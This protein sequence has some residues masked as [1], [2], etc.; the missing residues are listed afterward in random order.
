MH[1]EGV[2]DIVDAIVAHLGLTPH[3]EG[4]WYAET[5]RDTPADGSY[6]ATGSPIGMY[7]RGA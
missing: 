2:S 3:P 6:T 5:W 1:T 4:G 7:T